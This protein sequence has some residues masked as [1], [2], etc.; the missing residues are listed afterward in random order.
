[1]HT[2]FFINLAMVMVF[3]MLNY[4]QVQA[5]T[6][7]I[8]APLQESVIQEE[9]DNS[10]KT[11]LPEG[12]Q[13]TANIP[14]YTKHSHESI[15]RINVKLPESDQLMHSSKILAQV[16]INTNKGTKLYGVPVE[17]IALGY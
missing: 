15:K 13:W 2:L 8:E 3:N 11:A 10:L 14:A 16:W 6:S 9:L 4:S 12:S 5:M 1:M 7:E 17:I